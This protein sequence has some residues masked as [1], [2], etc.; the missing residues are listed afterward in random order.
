MNKEN[1]KS[2]QCKTPSNREGI[3][4]MPEEKRYKRGSIEEFARMHDWA[5]TSSINSSNRKGLA[6]LGT[7]KYESG[8]TVE[9][10]DR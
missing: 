10:G 1:L 2:I 8:G 3:K 5:T 6:R 4:Y 9:N 7:V